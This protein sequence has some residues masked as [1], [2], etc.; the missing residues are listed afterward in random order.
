MPWKWP[1]EFESHI[2]SKQTHYIETILVDESRLNAIGGKFDVRRLHSDPFICH[3]IP[4]NFNNI[5]FAI[6]S[7]SHFLNHLNAASAY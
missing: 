4:C 6:P 5:L 7:P 3:K 2:K 1:R